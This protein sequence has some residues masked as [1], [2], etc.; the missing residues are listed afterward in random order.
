MAERRTAVATA[1]GSASS[2]AIAA[3]FPP[4]S[5]LTLV[6]L[7]AHTSATCRPEAVD[8]VNDTL[9]T[10]GLATRSR[11][12]LATG[13]NDAD[14][15]GRQTDLL[16]HLGEEQGVEWGFRRRLH[17]DGAP[18]QQRRNQ[19]RDDEELRHVPRDHGWTTPTGVRRTTVSARSPRRTSS[20]GVL[21]ASLTPALMISTP[22][23]AW[24]NWL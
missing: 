17:D 4:S 12:S 24:A 10:P 2:S 9:S 1:R 21:A 22:G 18:R 13:G 20:H 8:P 23:R 14:D 7:A 6:K 19:L 15:S 5:R 11:A 16:E 3:D